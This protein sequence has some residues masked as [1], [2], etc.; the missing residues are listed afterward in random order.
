MFERFSQEAR[1]VVV[2][3][4]ELV[5]GM[6]HDHIGADHLLVAIAAAPGSGGRV[7]AGLGVDVD[8]LRRAVAD[9]D[10][11]DADA[12][13]SLGIDLDAV[14]R[15]AEEAFGPGALD[16]R[17]R[18]R[19]LLGRLRRGAPSHLPFDATARGALEASLRETLALG[20]REIT[21][22]HL[23]LGALADAHGPA[24]RALRAAGVPDG[25]T[26]QDDLRRQV[27][28]SLEQAA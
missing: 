11:H 23:L 17:P 28:A 27:R 19:G 2:G 20:H 1:R 10:L 16:R 24:R 22:G 21:T 25:R 8:V 15:Q 13:G 9:Q 26:D 5:R 12:L 14:R 4:Q 3:A 18:R 6:G 7:L